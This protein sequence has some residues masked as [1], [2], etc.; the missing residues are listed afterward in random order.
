MAKAL[1]AYVMLSVA[2]GA[3]AS[4]LKPAP[5]AEPAS[6]NFVNATLG[7]VTY[8]NKVGTVFALVH[9]HH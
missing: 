2:L 7:G 4:K 3:F 6:A 1:S 9:P 5:L 8:T